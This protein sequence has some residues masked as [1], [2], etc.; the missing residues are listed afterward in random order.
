[1]EVDSSVKSKA[2]FI[3]FPPIFFQQSNCLQFVLVSSDFEIYQFNVILKNNSV[4]HNKRYKK[5]LFFFW[6]RWVAK[7]LE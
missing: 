1:M 5:M 4:Q 7:E 2:V 6:H 3:Y